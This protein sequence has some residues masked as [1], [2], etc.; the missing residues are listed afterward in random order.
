MTEPKHSNL[1]FVG[2]SLIE[3]FDWQARFP[4][5]QVS[6]QGVAGE[7]AQGL[8]RRCQEIVTTVP[9]PD[10]LLI[11]IGTNNVVM[12]DFSFLPTYEAIIDT[13]VKAYPKSS[14]VVNGLFPMQL[15]W[16]GHE[17]VADLNQYLAQLAQKKSCSYLDG[18][19]VVGNNKFFM[20]DGVHISDQG[21]ELWS[22]A[23]E[24]ILTQ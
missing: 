7:T 8:R 22:A 6:N 11:M 1:L 9:A 24:E 14:I 23:V 16:L 10:W 21:Y 3:Y 15:P 2:D 17:A 19:K 20:A 5:L 13:L 18:C 12:E 4:T